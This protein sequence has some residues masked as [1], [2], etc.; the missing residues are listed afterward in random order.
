M[1]DWHRRAADRGGGGL[2]P[3]GFYPARGL[4]ARFLRRHGFAAVT[5]P[6]RRV[7]VLDEYC[8]RQDIIAHERVHLDQI[9]RYGPLF[10][11]I[12]YLYWL[13]IY[14]YDQHPLEVEAYAKAPVD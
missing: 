2:R 1:A 3:A 11:T 9:E 5:M 4:L 13:A 12:L 8:G 6:W 7:Y 10:F 14:G